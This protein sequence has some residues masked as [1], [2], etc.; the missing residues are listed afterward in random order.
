MQDISFKCSNFPNSSAINAHK[1]L[2]YPLEHTARI[3]IEPSLNACIERQTW[4]VNASPQLLPI[5]V[6]FC[7][8]DGD[9][10][11]IGYRQPC[12]GDTN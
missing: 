12:T 4:Q 9:F 11:F 8:A 2:T 5:F 10:V 1:Q 7:R 6:Y 3:F